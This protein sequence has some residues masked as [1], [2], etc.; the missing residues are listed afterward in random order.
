MAI[1]LGAMMCYDV[2]E[3]YSSW[4]GTR[5]VFGTFSALGG[6][7][8]YQGLGH[9]CFVSQSIPG[10]ARSLIR[11][12]LEMVCRRSGVAWATKRESGKSKLKTKMDK[13]DKI[14]PL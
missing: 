5:S 7:S 8:L 2:L 6:I 9:V 1:A 12:L 11:S 10:F 14:D 13:I 3:G 4:L